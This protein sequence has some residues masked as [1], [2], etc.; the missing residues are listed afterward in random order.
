M[1]IDGGRGQLGAARRA[2]S[3]FKFPILAIAKGRE[4]IFSTTL[5]RPI[6]LATMDSGVR[7]L[8]FHIDAEAHRFAITYYRSLHKRTVSATLSRHV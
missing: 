6:P 7:N 2:I 4:E 3:N 1:L 5:D 8:L